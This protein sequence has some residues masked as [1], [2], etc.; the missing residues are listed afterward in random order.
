M[1]E[2]FIPAVL[3]VSVLGCGS[4]TAAQPADGRPVIAITVDQTGYTP[5]EVT[6][7]GGEPVR[8]VFTRTSDD[9]CG[10]Q[11]VFKDQKIRK[12]LPLQSPVA[13]DITMPA[14]GKVTFSCGMDM[15]RGAVVI[16]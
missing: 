13:V 16:E 4:E 7:K 3:W 2:L 15:Y 11:L 5:A 12:D 1:R 8:L 14:S 10:Q 6:A 9:G